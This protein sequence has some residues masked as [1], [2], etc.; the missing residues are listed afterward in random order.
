MTFEGETTYR[1]E[2]RRLE[3]GKVAEGTTDLL[4]D[5]LVRAGI[6]SPAIR[7]EAEMIHA[8]EGG[9]I[10]HSLLN[11]GFC[12]RLEVYRHWAECLELPFVDLV[13]DPPDAALLQKLGPDILL[14]GV[15]VPWRLKVSWGR[16]TL[17]VAKA[18]PDVRIP[19]SALEKFDIDHLEVVLTTDWD[20]LEAVSG[21]IGNVMAYRAA[22][23]L[24][25]GRPDLS[26]SRGPSWLQ[27]S[28]FGSTGLVMLALMGWDPFVGLDVLLTVLNIFFDISVATKIL[29]CVVGARTVR[30]E[31][32]ERLRRLIKEGDAP[33]PRVAESDL[34][35]FTILVPCYKEANVIPQILSHIEELDYPRSK[36]QVLLLL[37]VDD[38][39]SIEAAKATRTPDYMRIVVVP[40]GTPRTKARACN[41]GLSLASGE[42]LVI[43]DAEDRP[44]A[45]QLRDVVD[46]FAEL[47]PE[48][49]CLQARLNYFNARQNFLTRMFTLE[50][51]LWFDYLLRGLDTLAIPMP[52]GGTS[53]HFRT[54][55]LRELNGWDPYNVTEDAD[56]G[57]R[58]KALGY[59]IGVINSTTWEEACSQVKPWIRQRTRW[60]KGYMMT[61]MVHSRSLRNL[62]RSTGWRGLASLVLF[63]GGTPL[64][65]LINPIVLAWGVY[66]IFGLPL[67][68]FRLPG[69]IT[70]L[71]TFSLL[72]GSLSMI[73]L[74]LLAVRRRR[75]W[76][77]IGFAFLNPVYWLLHSTAAWRALLQLIRSPSEWEK[78]PH[79]L[80]GSGEAEPSRHQVTEQK[81]VERERSKL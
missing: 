70:E 21:G 22:E 67:P 4:L 74:N 14:E 61:T 8:R 44:E 80:E 51:S 18:D 43:Y 71:N 19:L 54:S 69:P 38:T 1:F 60:I 59:R 13:K 41:V 47:G 45:A 28:I 49:I 3:V 34:P 24:A 65:F 17:V 52:L 81:L 6:L 27:W 72:F 48:V 75:Q 20:V 35:T 29:F 15:W 78:T 62:R 7:I 58:A 63:I 50:Y 55:A 56:I 10:G 77:L 64:T 30:K 79:G 2:G 23:T 16:R 11:H 32:E 5:S 76:G 46:R 26:A 53:N 31:E 9:W 33:A 73:A 68:N 57:I 40:E 39:E 66:G 42:F 37:E 36:L 25:E 12:S